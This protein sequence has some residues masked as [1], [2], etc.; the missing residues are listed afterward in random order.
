LTIEAD[1]LI[2]EDLSWASGTG[3]LENTGIA[4]TARIPLV[5]HELV[6]VTVFTQTQIALS[7]LDGTER[8]VIDGASASDF[9]WSPAIDG[10]LLWGGYLADPHSQVVRQIPLQGIRV[11]WPQF[12]ADGQWIYFTNRGISGRSFI[13][14]ARLDGSE[15]TTVLR[16]GPSVGR[17]LS[18]PDPSHDGT[19]VAYARDE[20]NDSSQLHVL[21]LSD[22]GIT[23]LVSGAEPAWSPDDGWIAYLPVPRPSGIRMVRANGAGDREVTS[24]PVHNVFDWTSDGRSI[25]AVSEIDHMAFRVDV[26]TGEVESLPGLGPASGIRIIP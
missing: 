2:T 6:A 7:R 17:F 13:M 23:P 15:L 12:S 26:F 8:T 18:M 11:G 14:R 25:V 4:P 19:R 24:T 16:D 1:V 21:R 20:L 9:D 5:R 10:P 22:G 3:V